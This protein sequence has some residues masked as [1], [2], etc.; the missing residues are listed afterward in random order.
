M[1][2]IVDLLPEVGQYIRKC[3]TRTLRVAYL[4][5]ARQF[6]AQTRWL[7]AD[8]SL[9]TTNT[10]ANVSDY[11]LSIADATQE[12]VGI[13][14]MKGYQV[15]APTQWWPIK[16]LDAT[17]FNPGAGT[18]TPN[19]YAYVPDAQIKLFQTPNAAYGLTITAAVQ[20]KLTAT[21][22]DSTLVTKWKEVL[23]AGALE[24]LFGLPQQAWSNGAMMEKYGKVFH[25]G[26][27]NAKGDE[28]R[29]FNQGA[30]RVRPRRI[31]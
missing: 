22:I 8:A 25:A 10:V 30:Q 7:R 16:P 2:D 14:D 4:R 27:N 11:T 28:Q 20:P 6:C 17:E 29:G 19:R 18:G 21:A 13:R 26:I 24:Y 5:A 1:T 3:P 15:S 23:E 12:I 31:I 9:V